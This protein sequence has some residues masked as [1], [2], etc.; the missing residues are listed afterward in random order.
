MRYDIKKLKEVLENHSIYLET[1]DIS[2]RADLSGADLSCADLR[3]AILSQK[4]D[5][6]ETR[7]D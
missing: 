2:K 4:T 6:P 1:G 5:N 3:G 7:H